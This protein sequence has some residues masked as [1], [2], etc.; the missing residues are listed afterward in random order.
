VAV[1][2]CASR[3]IEQILDRKALSGVSKLLSFTVVESR[4]AAEALVLDD[5]VGTEVRADRADVLAGIS[6]SSKI[7]EAAIQPVSNFPL[8]C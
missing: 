4:D 8:L 1:F 3:K 6:V 5:L 7:E 2:L